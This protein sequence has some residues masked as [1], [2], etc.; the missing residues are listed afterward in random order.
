DG[1]YNI[2][3]ESASGWRI[4]ALVTQ[5]HAGE[6]RNPPHP[7]HPGNN[8]SCGDENS[9]GVTSSSLSDEPVNS[10]PGNS[11]GRGNGRGR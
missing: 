11:G 3:D 1:A 7:D 9:G 2:E 6:N 4:L 8:S 10:G 5:E